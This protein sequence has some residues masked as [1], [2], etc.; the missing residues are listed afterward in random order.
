MKEKRVC[1]Q[2]SEWFEC[3]ER[4]FVG[5]TCEK[6]DNKMEVVVCRCGFKIGIPHKDFDEISAGVWGSV[7]CPKCNL[8]LNDKLFEMR[9]NVL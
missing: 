6:C 5:K 8:H 1:P 2:C 9:E 3:E 7:L 4:D